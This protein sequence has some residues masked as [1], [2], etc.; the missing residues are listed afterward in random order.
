MSLKIAFIG[1][2]KSANRYHLPYLNIRPD[3][4]LAMVYTR[5][6]VDE[7]LSKPYQEN[8]TVFT[9]NLDDVLNN[10]QIDLVTICTPAST[11]YELAKSFILSNK[12][13]IVEK[14]F[15]DSVEHAKELLSLGKERGVLVTPYQ[16]RRFDG[17]FLAVKKVI[18]QGFLGDILE[19]ESHIDYYRPGTVNKPGTK[20]QGTF[21]GLGIH[22]MDRMV[23]LF[24]RPDSVVYDIRNNEVANAVDNYFDVD[25]HYGTQ[26]KIKVKA[27]FVV[28]TDYP[29]FI[30]HGTN[31][32]F[33]KYGADQQENDLKAGIMPGTDGFG[34]DSPM[35]YGV[36]KYRNS[37]GDWIEKQIKTPVGDYGAFYDDVYETLINDK[38]KLVTDEQA[39]TDIELLEAGFK[40]PSPSVYQMPNFEI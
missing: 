30:V 16:N 7:A 11:H 39:I 18:E 23:S 22:L 20:E 19:V 27:E 31:G 26:N 36:A 5:K 13:V 38:P 28:A 6:P 21:Y 15:V 12:S 35:Y 40:Q 14:P 10:P 25:L 9:T 33:I 1:F 29:R 8:G 4:E 24:G 37:N 2:G 34:E 32:S 3:F 17:D